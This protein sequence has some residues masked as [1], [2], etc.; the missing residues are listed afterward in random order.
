MAADHCVI[1]ASELVTSVLDGGTHGVLIFRVREVG[2][3]LV[4]E[5][6][7]GRKLHERG[8]S[9]RRFPLIR[10]ARR[11]LGC[12]AGY[13]AQAGTV[14]LHADPTLLGR[15]TV[16]HAVEVG[17]QSTAVGLPA[18]PLPGGLTGRRHVECEEV[19][20]RT[21]VIDRFFR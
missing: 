19:C 11:D 15:K 3:W 2:E 7:E 4:R 16:V 9:W 21:E 20:H 12:R 6:R 18:E 17:D 10:V 1:D 8:L 14:I 13:R 5:R